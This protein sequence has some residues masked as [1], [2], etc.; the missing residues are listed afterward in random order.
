[1]RN[2]FAQYYGDGRIGYGCNPLARVEIW[3]TSRPTDRSGGLAIAN[4]TPARRGE[5]KE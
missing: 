3:P 5:T 1:V 2:P 4:E